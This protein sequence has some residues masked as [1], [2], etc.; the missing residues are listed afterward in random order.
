MRKRFAQF[1]WMIPLFVLAATI[2]CSSGTAMASEDQLILPR[3][4][5]KSFMG[6]NGQIL[7]TVGL[8]IAFAGII[9]GLKIYKEL[10]DLPVHRSMLEVSDLIYE[11]CKTYL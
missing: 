4:S 2:F 1:K 3:L 11:T 10:K 7:L 5:S 6:I 9:F 8:V